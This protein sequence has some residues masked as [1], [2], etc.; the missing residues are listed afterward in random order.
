MF[1]G[2][3]NSCDYTYRNSLFSQN[4]RL[5]Q[6]LGA[7]PTGRDRSDWR[8]SV[9]APSCTAASLVGDFNGWDPSA[10]PMTRAENGVWSAV[11]SGIGSGALYK[12]C[13]Q[14]RDGRTIYRADPCARYAEL[15]PGTAFRTWHDGYRWGDAQWRAQQAAN[16]NRSM[17]MAIYEVHLGSWRAFDSAQPLYRAAAVPLAEYAADNGFTHIELM[18]I[19]EYPFDGSWGYQ[20]TG[21]FAP[22]SRY[23]T[24]ED[25]KY[26]VDTMHRH[27]VGVILDWVPAHFPR[28]EQGL[29]Q[30]DGTPLFEHP[31]P[32][33]A[34]H[35][36]WGTLRFNCDS[37][38]VKDFLISNALFWLG[39]YHLDGLRADAVSSMLYLDYERDFPLRNRFGGRENLGAIA[40]FRALNREVAAR[41]PSALTIAEEAT[42]FPDITAPAACGGL[43]FSYKWNMGWMNDTLRYM[44]TDPLFRSGNHSL[45]TFSM[46]YAFSEHFILPLSHDECVHGKK[47]LLDK[48]AGDYAVKFASLRTYLTYMFTHPGKK[49]LF[50]GTEFG[51]F[52]EWRYY[53]PLEWK[54]KAYDSH[55][56]LS[57]F[58]RD[59]VRFYRASEALWYND[60]DW[61]GFKWSNA[62]DA[63]FEVFSYFR[64]GKPGDVLLCVLNMTPVER[65]DY[66]IG[67]PY[68]GTYQLVLNSDDPCYYGGGMHVETRLT[69]QKKRQGNYPYL[70]TAALP[71]QSALIYRWIPNDKEQE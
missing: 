38:I 40:M 25:F 70:L 21:Y 26:F 34:E 7:H 53:E 43:G 3:D 48:M 62:D 5:P 30:F 54:L 11:V 57:E 42:D 46:V 36:Q 20:V 67:T 35:V 18:P 47:S 13:F 4:K 31:D 27:G 8:F 71:P 15:R 28:D 69:T 64:I 33:I 68:P 17:P 10:T 41:F 61:S 55:R 45:M 14:T 24:P 49:L 9:Y 59:L 63:I 6:R 60:T 2:Y 56:K 23:G 32:R 50:M 65:S 52:L 29:R 51:P 16:R 19:S 22:T 39:E 12:F 44:E 58:V 1:G 66:L 37:D